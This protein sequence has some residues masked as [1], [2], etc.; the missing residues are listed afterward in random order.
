MAI[1]SSIRLPRQWPKHVKSGILH[2]ISLAGVV[3]SCAREQATSRERLRA[4]LERAETEIAL[5]REELSIKDGRCWE[6][7]RSGSR[8]PTERKSRRVKPRRR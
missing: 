1:C 2:A 3:L 4:R 7:S 6:R 5:L 8:R